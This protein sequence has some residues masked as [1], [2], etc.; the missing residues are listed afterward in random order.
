[1]FSGSEW[2]FQV[3]VATKTQQGKRRVAIGERRRD[4]VIETL[5]GTQNICCHSLQILSTGCLPSMNDGI[6]RSTFVAF[7]T[8][9][10]VSACG[11]IDPSQLDAGKTHYFIGLTRLKTAE[12]ESRISVYKIQSL[13][14]V[15]RAGL[16]LGLRQEQ[17][18]EVPLKKTED[19]A[20][21]EATCSLVVFVGTASELDHANQLFGHLS[22]ED[23]CIAEF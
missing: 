1:M 21:W 22:G 6:V 14:L 16:T 8:V 19:G 17:M 10:L 9:T 23:V 18:I 15:S 7:I 5:A 12:P 11:T 13:G 2:I 3:P 20:P 4:V